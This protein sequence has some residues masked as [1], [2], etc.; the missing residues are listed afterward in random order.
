MCKT[1]G[2]SIIFTLFSIVGTA[3]MLFLYTIFKTN[4][5]MYENVK[6]PAKTCKGLFEAAI[7]YLVTALISGG[8]WIYHVQKAKH[9]VVE[10]SSVF[11][12]SKKK[13]HFSTVDTKSA[14]NIPLLKAQL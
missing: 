1:L 2:R 10:E 12:E 8:F 14:E 11:D 13:Y 6:D 7:A 5:E 3:F 4:P 9:T